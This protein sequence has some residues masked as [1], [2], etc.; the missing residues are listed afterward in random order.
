[1]KY[2]E[3]MN[4]FPKILGTCGPFYVV[5][6]IQPL[7]NYFLMFYPAWKEDFGK[8]AELALKVLSFLEETEKHFPFL[9]FCDIKVGHFGLDKNLD[10]KLLDMDMVFFE[11]SL[12]KNIGAIQNCSKDKDC[13]F[14]DCRGS[15]NEVTGNC[16]DKV[17]DNNFQVCYLFSCDLLQKFYYYYYLQLLAFKTNWVTPNI[18]LMNIQVH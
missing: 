9:H 2:Y 1:M 8:R 12:K 15:C 6:F 14:I 17:L 3:D 7:D 11:T 10:V 16:E 18:K 5:E 13:S 4:V